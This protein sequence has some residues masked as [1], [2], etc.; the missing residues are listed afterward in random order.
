MDTPPLI[1][2]D[3]WDLALAALLVLVAAGVSIIMKLKIEESIGIAAAR[4]VAQLLLLGFVLREIFEI[5]NFFVLIPLFVIMVGVASRA[6]VKRTSRTFSGIQWNSFCTLA[7]VG[8]IVSF[9][10]TKV[11]IGASPWWQPRYLI[12]LL[13]MILGN[14]L[15]AIS[16]A[17]DYM[18]ERLSERKAE[19]EM[20]LSLGATKWEAAK[21]VVSSAIKRGMIPIINNM[22]VIGVVVLP[23]LMTGQILSGTDPLEAVKYQIVVMFMLV[24]AI[25]LGCIAITMLI[26]KRLFNDKHQLL[27]DIIVKK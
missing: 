24:A 12:P 9:T 16:L 11:V 10:V 4:M 3:G 21:D 2:L 6:S 14:I 23:G 8:I 7:L 19:V 20:E 17:I 22:T 25:S 18:L 1:H 5:D 27:A 26:Y 15:T 13:G